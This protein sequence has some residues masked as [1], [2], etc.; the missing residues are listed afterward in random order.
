MLRDFKM[1]RRMAGEKGFDSE[2]GVEKSGGAPRPVVAI[3]NAADR[4]AIRAAKELLRLGMGDVILT[5]CRSELKRLCEEEKITGSVEIW[6][7][8]GEEAAAEAAVEAVQ[9]QRAQVLMKGMVN[10][11]IFLKAVLHSKKGLRGEGL[12]CH[13]AAFEVPG[14]PKLQFHTDGGMNLLPNLEQKREILSLSV[15]ALHRMGVMVPRVAVLSAN[16]LVNPRLPSSVEARRLQEWS[17]AGN[18]GGCIVEGPV[19]MDVALSKEAAKHKGLKSRV[20]GETDLF[21]LPGIEAANIVGKALMYCAKARMAGVILGASC[22]IV[23]ASRA[24]DAQAKLNS[25]AMALC[26]R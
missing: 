21:L 15:E 1:L 24:D 25:L 14:W 13:L 18:L 17:E 11:S 22:P 16:E 5:G 9:T 19:A 10:S 8:S 7:A 2:T 23:M 6:D 3:A 20:A 4:E 12:L 26:I